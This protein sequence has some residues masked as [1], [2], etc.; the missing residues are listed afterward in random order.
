MAINPS[1]DVLVFISL[2][3]FF[4]RMLMKLSLMFENVDRQQIDHGIFVLSYSNE[5]VRLLSND[6]QKYREKIT[7]C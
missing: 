2:Y 5:H 3:S 1:I 6:E 7:Y 4:H